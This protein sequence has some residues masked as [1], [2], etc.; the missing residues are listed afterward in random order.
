MHGIVNVELTVHI[1]LEIPGWDES[2][3]IGEAAAN[4]CC[5]NRQ[6]WIGLGHNQQRVPGDHLGG[7]DRHHAGDNRLDKTDIFIEILGRRAGI[8]LGQE[9]AQVL[10]SL[11]EVLADDDV[12]GAGT[13]L[14]AFLQTQGEQAA[15]GGQCPDTRGSTDEIGLGELVG[16]GIGF[17]GQNSAN[18]SNGK[19]FVTVADELKGIAAAMVER[20]HQIAIYVNKDH[21]VSGFGEK[22]T[23]KAPANSARAKLYCSFHVPT[24]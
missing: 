5:I 11:V 9:V 19:N 13:I 6:E 17:L 4:G 22:L 14:K 16:D 8:V 15:N 12:D 21:F 20:I 7:T 1:G 18:I 23:Q 10:R 2:F 24:P 3:N